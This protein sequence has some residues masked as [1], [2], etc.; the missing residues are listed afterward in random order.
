[1][2]LHVR[3]WRL[4]VCRLPLGTHPGATGAFSSWV[5]APT[6][7]SLVCEEGNEPP[8]A[9]IESGWR[10]I[11]IQGPIPFDQV[12]VL[13]SV[14]V[15]LAEANVPIFAISTYDTDVVLVRGGDLARAL[16]A[17]REAGHRLA[18]SEPAGTETP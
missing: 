12:G 16:V 8:G 3:P 9:R 7:T 2:T 14:L 6:E 13:A 15:P 18:E 5:A 11:E 17:L 1:M 4:S 10:A